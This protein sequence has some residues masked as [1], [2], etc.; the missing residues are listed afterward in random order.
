MALF[1][2]MTVML[3]LL[4]ATGRGG[5]DRLRAAFNN[6]I[7]KLSRIV[8]LVGNDVVGTETV[9]ERGGLRDVMTLTSRQTETQRIAQAIDADVNL[10]AEATTTAS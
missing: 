1:V 10:G 4:I 9:D 6:Q 7:K 2:Q 3:A 5:N 8:G